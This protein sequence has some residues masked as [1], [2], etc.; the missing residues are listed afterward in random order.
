MDRASFC[1]RW[2][3]GGR[4]EE[5][6]DRLAALFEVSQREVG[7]PYLMQ[8]VLNRSGRPNRGN[9]AHCTYYPVLVA[10]LSGIAPQGEPERDFI[11]DLQVR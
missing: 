1:L 7:D 8:E 11:P 10:L 9:K 2:C 3:M 5:F 6:R 4:V